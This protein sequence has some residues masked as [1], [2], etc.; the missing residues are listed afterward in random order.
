M[1]WRMSSTCAGI[2]VSLDADL[3]VRTPRCSGSVHDGVHSSDFFRSRESER[4]RVVTNQVDRRAR[5]QEAIRLMDLTNL[6]DACS[7]ED[8]DRLCERAHGRFGN[9]AAVCVWPR[10][11]AHAKRLLSST[12]IGIATVVNFP[13]GDDE[14]P[15][16]VSLV[17]RSLIDG[18]D[19]IDLVLPYRD[20]L[21]GRIDR[22]TAVL[23]AVRATV[24]PTAHL[25]V[26]LETG[27]LGQPDVIASAARFAIDHGADFVK[28]ST[29]KTKVSAT[30]QAARIMLQEIAR[31]GRSVGL[32]P[33]GGIRTLDDAIVYLDL[34]DEVMGTGWTTES[35]FRFG[36]SG[37]LDAL[38][39]ELGQA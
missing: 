39:A 15:D 6:D 3:R 18:A 9:V 5:A 23:D 24:P 27:E 32:K 36:A 29:G 14:L 16:I 30:V 8:V 13:S 10:F 22:V 1:L 20:L 19:D 12:G 21:A 11:V 37:L 17:E 25:K 31:S 28:T 35:T 38:E 7:V 2:R 34:A 26:I 33:S 4:F